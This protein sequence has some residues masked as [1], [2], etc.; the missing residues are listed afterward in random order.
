MN[1]NRL[2]DYLG[3][4][5]E[6]ARLASSYVEGMDKKK[7]LGDKRT[8]QAV[9]LNIVVIGEAATKLAREYP[10]FIARNPDVPWRNIKGMRNRITHGYF[11][12]DLDVVWDTL[13]IALPQLVRQLSDIQRGLPHDGDRP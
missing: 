12:I 4:R 13:Q 6:A 7:F 10:E 2:A 8:Q 11:D 3:H 5:L 9:I 1:E